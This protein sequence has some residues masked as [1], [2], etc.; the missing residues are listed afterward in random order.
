[1]HQRDLG[2][3]QPSALHGEVDAASGVNG[4]EDRGMTRG[5]RRSALVMLALDVDEVSIAG[6]RGGE[7]CTVHSV[8]SVLELADNVLEH[9][10]VAGRQIGHFFLLKAPNG[11][12][13]MTGASGAAINLPPH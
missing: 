11:R 9:S 1:M 8:P 10:S 13:A 2:P 7:R 4:P 5:N 6:K 12:R 3:Q